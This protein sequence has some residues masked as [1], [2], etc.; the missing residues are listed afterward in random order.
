MAQ[1]NAEGVMNVE[2]AYYHYYE[3]FPLVVPAGKRS[4]VTIRPLFDHALFSGEVT[5]RIQPIDGE[6]TPG[7]F[8]YEPLD[9]V[10]FSIAADGTMSVSADFFGE[11]QHDIIVTRTLPAYRWQPERKQELRFRICSVESDLYELRP[12]KG[13]FHMHSNGSDGVDAPEYVA[14]RCREAGFDFAALTDHY[15]YPP[16]LRAMR[17]TIS[18]AA[19][20]GWTWRAT[21]LPTRPSSASALNATTTGAA[22]GTA[23]RPSTAPAIPITAASFDAA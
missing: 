5:V 13:D 6:R 7:S 3:V 11:Q 17:T 21:F 12:L 10:E 4:T 9:G 16:S 18:P 14:V 2:A 22:A 1:L 23:E 20:Y 15:S 8:G 19:A